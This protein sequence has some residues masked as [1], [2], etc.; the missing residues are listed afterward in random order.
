MEDVNLPPFDFYVV[1]DGRWTKQGSIRVD[2]YAH[3]E[4]VLDLS[5]PGLMPHPGLPIENFT[6]EIMH[7]THEVMM[8]EHLDLEAAVKKAHQ[9]IYGHSPLIVDTYL[10]WAEKYQS[11]E[12]FLTLAGIKAN[13]L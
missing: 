7:Q 4:K 9:N 11:L 3:V 10:E 12:Y 2:E 8:L 6:Q 1:K 13:G 5:P